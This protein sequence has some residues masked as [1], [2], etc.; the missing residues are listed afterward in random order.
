M[1]RSRPDI[2]VPTGRTC[3]LQTIRLDHYD[4]RLDQELHKHA[5]LTEEGQMVCRNSLQSK[6][7]T[8]RLGPFLL[9]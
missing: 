4:R 8:D 9:P 3:L 2:I 7:P 6:Y 1:G 5:F